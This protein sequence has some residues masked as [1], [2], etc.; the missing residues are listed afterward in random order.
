M[1]G[2]RSVVY[3]VVPEELGEELYGQLR[4]FFADHQ[5]VDV[6]LDRRDREIGRASCRERVLPTV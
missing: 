4:A 6:V 3:C 1:A 2:G 5:L